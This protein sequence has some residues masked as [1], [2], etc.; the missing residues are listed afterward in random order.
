MS[1]ERPDPALI[2]ALVEAWRGLD[3]TVEV[4]GLDP[5]SA[6]EIARR[7]VVAMLDRIDPEILRQLR[8]NPRWRPE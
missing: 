1:A 7:H 2:G 4:F 5:S 3:Y 8:R 6:P